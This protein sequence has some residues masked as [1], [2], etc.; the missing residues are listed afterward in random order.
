[1]T[2]TS[3]KINP[4]TKRLLVDAACQ[5]ALILLGTAAVFTPTLV[6]LG[7]SIQMDAGDSLLNLLFLENGYLHLW[8]GEH[9]LAWH[10]W[11]NPGYFYP[12]ANVLAWSDHALIPSALY[13][14]WRHFCEP[15]AA[16]GLWMITTSALNFIVLTKV[17][18]RFARPSIA[19]AIAYATSYGLVQL[20]QLGHSQ[21]LSQYFIAP[22]LLAAFEV[23]V[24]LQRAISQQERF[25]IGPATAKI[26][27]CALGVVGTFLCSFYLFYTLLV[28]IACLFFAAI[29]VGCLGPKPIGLGWPQAGSPP[30]PHAHAAP[31]M[32]LGSGQAKPA[33]WL[34]QVGM[35]VA[36][37]VPAQKILAAYL[38][39]YRLH[40]GRTPSLY[41]FERPDSFQP[42]LTT[43][44]QSGDL[45]IPPPVTVGALRSDITNLAENGLFNGYV[46]LACFFLA[47]AIVGRGSVKTRLH[48]PSS[49]QRHQPT[50]T[51][52]GWLSPEGLLASALIFFSASIAIGLVIFEA[53]DGGLWQGLL[54]KLPGAS[55][56][57]ASSRFGFIQ[58]YLS[59]IAM[60]FSF[61]LHGQSL[62]PSRQLDRL[63]AWLAGIAVALS[64]LN[65]LGTHPFANISSFFPTVRSIH[66]Q[67][68]R[69]GCDVVYLDA[70][71][72]NPLLANALALT[73]A[74]QLK[75]INGYSGWPSP[76]AAKLDAIK[77]WQP[78]SLRNAI[79]QE[80]TVAKTSA[81]KNPPNHLNYCHVGRASNGTDLTFERQSSRIEPATKQHKTASMASPIRRSHQPDQPKG[82]H[83]G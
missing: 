24:L 76:L 32:A 37:L 3:A 22:C 77:N 68:T 53:H 67:A 70:G 52:M 74:P 57:R 50:P 17:L 58:L 29:L 81:N 59:S 78:N 40:G 11:F 39:A 66:L 73:P 19:L 60:A 25:N 5:L 30:S 26:C 23:S 1:M 55:A 38:G 27:G 10:E 43:T 63:L 31:A 82:L 36:L 14:I 48:A 54:S 44:F 41:P 6:G 49:R 15:A 34:L 75:V 83:P 8:G 61:E 56:I 33:G 35:L 28:A 13:G 4:Q 20:S 64:F 65:T 47:L 16:Y 42:W 2:T 80:P 71:Q 72:F 12:Y 9:W 51:P 45:L 18:R 62:P 7:S 21:L 46:Y 79:E 69:Q